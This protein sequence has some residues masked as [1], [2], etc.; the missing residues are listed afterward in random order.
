MAKSVTNT[1]VGSF[2]SNFF[3]SIFVMVVNYF[4]IPRIIVKFTKKEPHE[5]KSDMFKA[6]IWR[7]FFFLTFAYIL[8]PL[9]GFVAISQFFKM[10]ADS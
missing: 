8:L 2:F 3:S 10:G 4:L 1:G 9:A 7:N 6:I 5:T